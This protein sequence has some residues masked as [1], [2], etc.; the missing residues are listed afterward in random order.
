MKDL[1][2]KPHNPIKCKQPLFLE[3]LA[4]CLFI[5][6]SSLPC[7]ANEKI[8]IVLSAD[9]NYLPYS[10]MDEGKSAGIYIKILQK[11]FER[12][13]SKYS[14]D[15]NL[16]PWGEAVES[17]KI[18]NA[19]GVF[20]IYKD[21]VNRPWMSYSEPLYKETIAVFCHEV[22]KK[23]PKDFVH[24]KVGINYGFSTSAHLSKIFHDN[25][26]QVFALD[27][28]ISALKFYRD[29]KVDCYVNDRNAVLYTNNFLHFPPV[30][31]IYAIEEQFSYL[32][33]YSKYNSKI[34]QDFIRKFNLR[35]QE[36]KKDGTIN[37]IV[38]K[39]LLHN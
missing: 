12:F 11:I 22:N 18:G 5:F 16:V 39:F 10:F 38:D 26:M 1:L 9:A 30:H 2:F 8:R 3:K 36:I 25:K 32:G 21:E 19:F 17:V 6:L 31:E 7:F 37:S 35:L 23:W 14:V 34:Q 24:S 15:I 13:D 20:P 28:N 4:V 27:N 29:K 33:F